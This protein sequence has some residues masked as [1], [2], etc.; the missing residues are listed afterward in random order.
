MAGEL[1]LFDVTRHNPIAADYLDAIPADDVSAA[2]IMWVKN[3]GSSQ[4]NN[5]TATITAVGGNDGASMLMLCSGVSVS[6]PTSA[7][8]ASLVTGT[9]V[10]PVDMYY[11]IAALGVANGPSLPSPAVM[12]NVASATGGVSLSWAAVANALGYAIYSSSD[13]VAY[14]LKDI[15]VGGTTYVDLDGVIDTDAETPVS[16]NQAFREG[17]Y[18]AGP[19]SIG[20]LDPGGM[21]PI[22]YRAE[23]PA[24][25]TPTL[26]TRLVDIVVEGVSA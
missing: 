8:A 16:V 9:I 21:Y 25:T 15:V 24:G 13:G 5:I 10:G 6:A 19:L 17:T 2:G 14:Y 18:G 12:I 7:P 23:V 11:K 1:A 3:V 22:I 20:S 4:V 26:N